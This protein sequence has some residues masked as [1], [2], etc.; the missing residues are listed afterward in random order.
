MTKEHTGEMSDEE[1]REVGNE[2]GHT[3]LAAASEDAISGVIA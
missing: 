2:G 3:E 1:I